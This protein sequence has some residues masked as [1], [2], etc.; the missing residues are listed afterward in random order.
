MMPR[1][2]RSLLSSLFSLP[3]SSPDCRNQPGNVIKAAITSS[4]SQVS[5]D[6]SIDVS[7]ENISISR[8]GLGE[9]GDHDLDSLFTRLQKSDA[10]SK[11]RGWLPWLVQAQRKVLHISLSSDLSSRYRTGLPGFSRDGTEKSLTSFTRSCHV[12]RTYWLLRT[13]GCA[14]TTAAPRSRPAHQLA[15][16]W[17]V[18]VRGTN[19]PFRTIKNNSVRH[20]TGVRC[21]FRN[22]PCAIN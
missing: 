18:P 11:H 21:G 15:V 16:V 20:E 14:V 2:T 5:S 6:L 13:L 22:R 4:V 10:R 12:S 3:A 9:I 8:I 17:H 7:C 19:R 1:P